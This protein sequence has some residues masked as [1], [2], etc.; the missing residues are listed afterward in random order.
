MKRR[1][2]H[3]PAEVKIMHGIGGRSSRNNLEVVIGTGRK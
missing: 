1:D 2:L 3:I